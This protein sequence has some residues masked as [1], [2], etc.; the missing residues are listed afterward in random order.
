MN[1]FG[2]DLTAQGAILGLTCWADPDLN[3]PSQIEQGK[4]WFN[5]DFTP[6]YPAE[7]VIF[8]SRIVNDFLEDIV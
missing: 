4:V 5:V 1:A 7:H 6:N 8:R 3:S 2:R